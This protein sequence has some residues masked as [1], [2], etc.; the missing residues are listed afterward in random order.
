MV[1]SDENSFIAA[2][3]KVSSFRKKKLLLRKNILLR[4]KKISFLKRTNGRLNLDHTFFS[5][6]LIVIPALVYTKLVGKKG[7]CVLY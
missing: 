2:R 5:P 7:A 3:K 1:K 4:G 6:T